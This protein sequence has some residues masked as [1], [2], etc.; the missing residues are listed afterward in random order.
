MIYF[1]TSVLVAYYTTEERSEDAKTI[2]EKATLPVV[3]DLGIA[4]FNVVLARKEFD[5]FLTADAAAQVFA[6]FDEHLSDAFVRVAIG[7]EHV[8]A[9]R[10]LPARTG[11]PL[12]TLDALHLAVAVD[13]GGAIATFDARLAEAGRALNIEVLPPLPGSVE[14]VPEVEGDSSAS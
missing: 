3:S 12:R 4:E 10:R 7:P 5:G 6:L 14:A 13:V 11:K 2:I 1:D 9:T 8:A